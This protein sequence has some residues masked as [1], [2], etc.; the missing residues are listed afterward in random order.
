MKEKKPIE[1]I[2]LSSIL[3][4]AAGTQ[5]TWEARGDHVEYAIYS[6]KEVRKLRNLFTNYCQPLVGVLGC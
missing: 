4:W 6:T 5:T 1:E 2:L 3:L